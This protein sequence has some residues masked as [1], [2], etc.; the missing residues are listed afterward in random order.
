L[1]LFTVA[2]PFF[3]TLPGAELKKKT[4]VKGESRKTKRGHKDKT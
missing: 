1:E 2:F 3:W 4:R